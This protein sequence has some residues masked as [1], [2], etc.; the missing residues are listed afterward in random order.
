MFTILLEMFAE[1]WDCKLMKE[2][3]RTYVVGLCKL[4]LKKVH[5]AEVMV[6]AR[7]T[8]KQ[9]RRDQINSD[10]NNNRV[11]AAEVAPEHHALNADITT[12]LKDVGDLK[13]K[14]IHFVHER[15]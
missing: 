6:V 15:E 11:T 7:I 2:F 5:E 1:H 4:A 13:D 9:A 14:V 3:C 12:V 8:E 10:I